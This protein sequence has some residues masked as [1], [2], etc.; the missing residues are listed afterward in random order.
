[1]PGEVIAFGGWTYR[2]SGDGVARPVLVLYDSSKANPGYVTAT[3]NN[4]TAAAWTFQQMSYTVPVGE[5]YAHFYIEIFG[6]RLPA[7]V[8]FDDLALSLG[9]GFTYTSK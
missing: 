6:N 7:D 5:A 9:A 1:M 3:P 4:V 8:R 2:V